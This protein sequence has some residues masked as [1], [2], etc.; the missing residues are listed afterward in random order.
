[1]T[2]TAT[3]YVLGL[4]LGTSSLKAVLLREDGALAA[5]ATRDYPILVP[6]PGWAEQR[7]DD[8]WQAT[9]AAIQALLKDTG[10]HPEQ[11]VAV[12]PGGQMHGTVLL[13]RAGVPVRSAIIWPDQRTGAEARRAEETLQA[14]GLIPRLGGGVATGFLLASLLWC[15]AHEPEIWARSSTVLLPKDYL[16]YRLTGVQASEPSDGSGVPAVDLFES[17]APDTQHADHPWCLPALDALNLPAALFPPLL[18]SAAQTGIITAQ[19]AAETGLRPG[20]PVLCGGSDQAM[21]AIGSDLLEP[22]SML[23]SLSTGG[24]I[25]TPLAAPLANPHQGLRTV[26][27]AL[28]HTYLALTATLGAGLSVRWLQQQVFEERSATGSDV[29]ALAAAAP[30]GASGLLFLPYLAGERAPLLDPAASGAFIGLRIDHSRAHLARAM[31]EGIA[32]SLRHALEPLY[33]AGVRP[34][35]VILAGGLARGAVMRAIMAAVLGRPVVP[36]ETPEQSALGAALLAAHF[37]GFYPS[38][39]A[40]C[41]ATVRFGSPVVP[42]PTWRAR[43]EDLFP[44]YHGLYP[45]LQSTMHA[46]RTNT[47]QRIDPDAHRR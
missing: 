47:G 20:T 11:V 1:M 24:Q 44:L 41:A 35:R 3:R 16:R 28:P 40:A 33:A 21:A 7:P 14:A 10:M 46:L 19:A 6:Q 23:V 18:P 30:P 22:G 39:P 2:A 13:D 29:Q 37:A 4:D 9:C 15:R 45:R 43:Y 38:L 42:D 12:C 34:E 31:L 5:R 27:H 17:H 32:F 25:V 8:W 36:L 26:C